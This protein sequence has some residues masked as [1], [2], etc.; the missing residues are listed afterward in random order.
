MPGNIE[1]SA[2]PSFSKAFLPEQ[3]TLESALL[4]GYEVFLD[5]MENMTEE[6]I[7]AVHDKLIPWGHP[8]YKSGAF[9]K[10]TEAIFEPWFEMVHRENSELQARPQTGQTLWCSECSRDPIAWRRYSRERGREPG[11]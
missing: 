2:M 4:S 7:E 11:T 3:M 1:T 6:P 5:D 8:G 9:A 10:H